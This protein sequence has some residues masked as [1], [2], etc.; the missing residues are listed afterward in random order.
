ME[1]TED[2]AYLRLSLP[3]VQQGVYSGHKPGGNRQAKADLP[4]MQKR[5]GKETDHALS[6]KDF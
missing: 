6:H 5:G 1:V 2:Y 4:Q 3:Q